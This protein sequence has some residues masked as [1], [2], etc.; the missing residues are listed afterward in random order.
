MAEECTLST[1]NLLRGSLPRN[2]VVS[3]TDRPDMTLA[4]DRGRTALT[5][6]TNQIKKMIISVCFVL[7]CFLT[8]ILTFN[9]STIEI[10]LKYCTKNISF[11][12]NANKTSSKTEL[13]SRKNF[14]AT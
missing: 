10:V 13:L 14:C 12:L 3:I 6:P 8:L 2:S 5:Q 1:G 9:A 11:K 7:I 4:V